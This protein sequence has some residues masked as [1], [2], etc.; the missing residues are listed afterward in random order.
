LKYKKQKIKYKKPLKQ[1]NYPKKIQPVLQ[2]ISKI[3]TR[4]GQLPSFV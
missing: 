4:M 1:M 2:W 3:T